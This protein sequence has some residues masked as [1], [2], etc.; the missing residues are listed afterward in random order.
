MTL[1]G[2]RESRAVAPE[3]G[4]VVVHAHPDDE[5]LATGALL[6]TWAAAGQAVTVV[7]CTRGERGEVIDTAEHPTGV[8][9]L[10]GDGAGLAAYR[11]GELRAALTAL[12]VRDHL[13]LDT[14]PLP[15][16]ASDDGRTGV[17]YEDSGMAWVAPGI[18]GAA[19]DGSG[20][21]P[22]GA[23]VGVGLDEAAARLAAVLGERRP[24]VVATYDPDGGYGHPDHVRAHQVTVRALELLAARPGTGTPPLWCVVQ[25]PDQVRAARRALA[26]APG[27]PDLAL[28]DPD[29]AVLPPVATWWH[30]AADALVV[31]PARPVQDRVAAALRAHA[32]QVQAVT[33]TE[34]A[35]GEAL[36]GW[37]ALSNDVLAPLPAAEHYAPFRPGTGSPGTVAP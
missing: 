1:G 36:V 6:A 25:P 35:E 11:E 31:V 4:L 16:D 13:F 9:A 12:G 8:G 32:T 18:A 21:R 24:A 23:F 27:L 33:V 20:A 19:S 2:G 15:G 14:V 34:P 3:G 5:T 30:G 29:E 10:E 22:E 26:A 17:R 7:T 28:P 37:Y